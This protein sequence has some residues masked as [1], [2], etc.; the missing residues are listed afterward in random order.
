MRGA[1]AHCFWSQLSPGATQIPQL[2][3]QQTCPV[4]QVLR[5]HI[6]IVFC[7]ISASAPLTPFSQAVGA[8]PASAPAPATPSSEAVVSAVAG[9]PPLPV[10]PAPVE[11][12]A[13]AP[14]SAALLA[15]NSVAGEGLSEA[16]ETGAA[17]VTALP[18]GAARS[19]AISPTSAA[20]SAA[21]IAKPKL[22]VNPTTLTVSNATAAIRL[23]TT[24]TRRRFDQRRG[25]FELSMIS[26]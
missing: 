9:A 2:A 20:A 17:A 3:L 4:L 25:G 26:T 15:P 18:V 16:L 24:T 23:E 1:P 8:A 12:A 10:A 5:P 14:V 7:A 22:C 11:G 19:G 6:E 21:S 13:D